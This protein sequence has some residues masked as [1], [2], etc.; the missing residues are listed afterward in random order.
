[1]PLFEV[2][3]GTQ[4]YGMRF[5]GR[6]RAMDVPLLCSQLGVHNVFD[7]QY[8][9][10][11]YARVLQSVVSAATAGRCSEA[12]SP[13][14]RSVDGTVYLGACSYSLDLANATERSIAQASLSS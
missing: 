7:P 5:A 2:A 11:W 4:C 8:P 6:V 13:G 12:H 14:G 10:G 3:A 1:M 9:S